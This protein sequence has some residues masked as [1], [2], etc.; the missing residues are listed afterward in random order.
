MVKSLFTLLLVGAFFCFASLASGASLK[1]DLQ[2][3]LASETYNSNLNKINSLFSNE[4]AF[5]DSRGNIDYERVTE[6]LRQ[7]GLLNLNYSG[8]ANMTLGFESVG[9]PLLLMKVVSDALSNMGYKYFLTSSIE[10]TPQMVRWSVFVSSRALVS[11]GALYS[12]LLKANAYIKG[13]AR[14]G[15]FDFAYV[16]DLSNAKV[17]TQEYV[18]GAM[19]KRPLEAYF[20][21]VSGANAVEI[22]AQSAD[23]WVP[24][25]KIFDKNLNLIKQIKEVEKRSNL[26]VELPSNAAYIVI[27]DAFSLENIKRGL[28]IRIN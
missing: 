11:P 23:S 20:Y 5:R 24:L 3:L 25:V 15:Q 14:V 28:S 18:E 4:A 1:D 22:S 7:N 21:G 13:I 2:N 19:P 17:K 26:N 10:N 27:D 9:S 12:E 16:I 6:V 8:G